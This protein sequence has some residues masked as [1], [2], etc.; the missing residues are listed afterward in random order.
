MC[1]R[2]IGLFA[3]LCLCASGHCAEPPMTKIVARMIVLGLAGDSIS[4]KP[5][6][7]Y[8]AGE[9]YARVEEEPDAAGSSQQLI[10]TNE[11]DSWMINLTDKTARHLVDAGPKFVTHAPIFWSS[12]G[13]PE[14]DFEEL[15]FGTELKFFGEG[16]GRDLKPRVVDGQKYKTV[17]I[18]TELHEAILLLDRK[19]GKPFQIDLIKFGRLVSSVR[20][21]SYQTNLPFDAS[22][23]QPPAD[24]KVTDPQ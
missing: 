16:R 7:I 21:V 19:T 1:R 11:P 20:Y 9:N 5:K 13:Q 14:H 10:V 4:A 18:K 22:L 2:Q 24:V 8:R 12:N 15:E 3:A 17:S 23:F 6:T